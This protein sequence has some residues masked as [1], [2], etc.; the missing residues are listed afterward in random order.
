[1]P[2]TDLVHQ[3]GDLDTADTESQSTRHP[4]PNGS[5][6]QLESKTGS[7]GSVEILRLYL[8]GNEWVIDFP[9]IYRKLSKI[10]CLF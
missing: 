6:P 9:V 5:I 1:M 10:E 8:S 7:Q 4:E 3:R 2:N